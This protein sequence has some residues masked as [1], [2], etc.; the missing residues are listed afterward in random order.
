DDLTLYRRAVRRL[1]VCVLALAVRRSE[2]VQDPR[3]PV[4]PQYRF[5]VALRPDLLR[6]LEPD[7][8]ILEENDQRVLRPTRG[9]LRLRESLARDPDVVQPFVRILQPL[10]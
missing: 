1:E 8:R 6:A 7:E 5:V 9:E 2:A 4:P 3:A 10:E